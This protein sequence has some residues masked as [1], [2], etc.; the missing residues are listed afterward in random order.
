[1]E[2]HQLRHMLAAAE[3]T[4][5]AQ[6]AKS[7]FTS[8]QNIAH[9]IKALESE[10]GIVLFER[11][12]NEMLLTPAGRQLASEAGEIVA[13]VD[14]LHVAFANSDAS[15][16]VL[17]LAVST[18]LF[19][20]IPPSTD[21]FIAQHADR[22]RIAEA[23]C[24]DCYRFVCSG[25]ADVAVIM[26]MERKFPECDV[27]EIGESASFALMSSSSP[28]ARKEGLAAADLKDQKLLLM[29]EPAFQYEPLFAQLDAL[30]FDRA[31]V[32]VIP[33]TSSMIHVVKRRGGT[34]IVSDKFSVAPPEG[35]CAIPL[36]DSRLNWRF[37]ILFKK[38]AP[39]F[40]TVAKFAQG[41][42]GTF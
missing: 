2:I 35:F 3:H 39:G 23:S 16:E 29:S 31:N 21:E 19:A 22:L 30:G 41:V 5:Y 25:K 32:S 6:A 24:A 28:L 8:R 33:S 27:L 26:C 40:P 11:R 14:G 20:G 17:N 10:L 36:S 12:G 38:G 34:G 37:Y 13:R 18:N 15:D 42:R 4:S 1:M 7:C 9:S